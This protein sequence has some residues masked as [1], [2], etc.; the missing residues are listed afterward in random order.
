M[1]AEITKVGIISCSGEAI[2]EGTISRL[3]T[4]RVLE[5]L[6]P[7]VTVTL[8][9][10]LFLAGNEAERNFARTHPTITI[11]GCEKQ[12]AKWGTEKHSGPVSGALVVSDI[13]GTESS[14]CHRS[15]RDASQPDKEA[16]WAVAERIAAEVDT[17]LA[18]V[19]AARCRGGRNQRGPVFVLQPRLPGGKLTI[20]GMTVSIPGLPLIFEQCAERGIPAD[21]SGGSALLDAVK[22]YHCVAAGGRSRIPKRVAC[23]VPGVSGA[24][25]SRRNDGGHCSVSSDR[26]REPRHR[27]GCGHARRGRRD[28]ICCASGGEALPRW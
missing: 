23:G 13:L 5:L 28:G 27:R 17:V 1:S 6:R 22:I 21:A 8:C 25:S 4:R 2:P 15:S 24:A 14:G 11:D 20:Q 7:D 26:R 9:L 10:P 3:A 16:V 12:C 18:A 19:E